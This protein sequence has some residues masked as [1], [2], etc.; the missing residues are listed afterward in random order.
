M[1]VMSYL[2]S[3]GFGGQNYLSYPWDFV[4]I[5]VVALIFYQWGVR[6]SLGTV[7]PQ[8]AQLNQALTK[9]H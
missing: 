8:A 6:S 4:V 2:G 7:D 1:A 3:S 5:V 9:E